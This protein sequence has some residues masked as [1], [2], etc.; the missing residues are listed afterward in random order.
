MPMPKERF[1]WLAHEFDTLVKKTNECSNMEERRTLLRRMRILIEEID[2]L[3][4]STLKR[5]DKEFTVTTS[6]DKSKVGS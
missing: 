4:S 3:I 5:D 6:S 1:Q 2:A